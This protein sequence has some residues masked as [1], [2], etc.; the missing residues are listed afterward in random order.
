MGLLSEQDYENVIDY[1]TQLNRDYSRFEEN[2]LELLAELFGYRLTAY[3]E[4]KSYSGRV[5]VERMISHTLRR[6]LLKQYKEA[7]VY[8]N[9]LI[10]NYSRLC[11]NNADLPYLTDAHLAGLPVPEH[12]AYLRSLEENHIGRYAVLGVNSTTRNL[13][14][15]IHIFM[16]AQYGDFTAHDL[17]LFAEIGRVFNLSK[18]LYSAH[19]QYVGHLETLMAYCDT[20]DFGFAILDHKGRLIQQN[21]LF[22]RYSSRISAGLTDA[23]VISDVLDAVIGE[24]DLRT[25]PN[26]LK[27]AQLAG[28]EIIVRK[29]RT[30]MSHGMEQLTFIT[31]NRIGSK[32]ALTI[33]NTELMAR[34]SFT[35]REAEVA[36]LIV[37]GCD[38]RQISENLFIA[39]P[40][41]KAHI[42]HIF[43]KAGVSSRGELVTV[44][45]SQG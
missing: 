13:V 35:K 18:N 6:D 44:I 16:P 29:K 12:S 3:C 38:N 28:L 17:A 15:L 19:M 5:E 20:A 2:S 10:T 39:L 23:E 31:L 37:L 26:F 24:R 30:E 22:K 45:R 11:Y 43:Q 21:S 27:T 7:G 9:P 40:T 14:H 34:F 41:V 33:D 1:Y 32:K 25:S 36:E 42:G 4:Y 8:D